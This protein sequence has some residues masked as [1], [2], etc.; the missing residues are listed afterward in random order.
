[1]RSTLDVREQ[2]FEE[3]R[4]CSKAPFG[5]APDSQAESRELCQ[6]LQN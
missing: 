1:M 2:R 5:T 6:T 3:P 4:R